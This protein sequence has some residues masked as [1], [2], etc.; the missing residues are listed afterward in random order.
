M[1]QLLF[2]VI[3]ALTGVYAHAAQVESLLGY[4]TDARGVH[5]QVNSG[6]CTYKKSFAVKPVTRRNA[7][8][9]TFMRTHHDPCLAMFY[10]GQML[11]FSY[12]ELGLRPGDRF[13]I[14]NPIDRL[15]EVAP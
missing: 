13:E 6:G 10:Y 2:I 5:I 3:A 1:K 11:T 4:Y 9:I 8:Q 12:R 7:M 14:T 15:H